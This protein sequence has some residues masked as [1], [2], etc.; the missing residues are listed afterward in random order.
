MIIN[1]RCVLIG[2]PLNFYG[3]GFTIQRST[4]FI[5]KDNFVDFIKSN[6]KDKN[7]WEEIKKTASLDI[8]KEKLDGG[9]YEEKKKD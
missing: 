5:N 3:G 6:A 1:K 7:F 2:T 9:I 8:P 4:I